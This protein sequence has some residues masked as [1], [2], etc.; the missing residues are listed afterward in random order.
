ML[1]VAEDGVYGSCIT[2]DFNSIS[3][4]PAMQALMLH[5]YSERYNFNRQLLRIYVRPF[6]FQGHVGGGRNKDLPENS[7]LDHAGRTKVWWDCCR[8]RVEIIILMSRVKLLKFCN[9]LRVSLF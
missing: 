5:L 9:E 6:I 1:I 7:G 3:H 8:R 4:T 2:A